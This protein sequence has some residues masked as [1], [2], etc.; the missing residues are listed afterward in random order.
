L[1]TL[2]FRA[3]GQRGHGLCAA[4]AEHAGGPGNARGSQHGGVDAALKGRRGD[5]HDFLHPRNAGRNNV[6]QHGRGIEGLAT[7]DI[8]A[9]A[10]ER[11]DALPQHAAVIAGFFPRLAQ[12]LLVEAADVVVRAF[13]DGHQFLGHR[14]D[15]GVDLV[16]GEFE[17][18]WDQGC[19]VEAL[20]IF[21]NGSVAA[22]ADGVDNLARAL[23]LV[24]NADARIVHV[25][26]GD[27]E[28]ACGLVSGV[29]CDVEA[30]HELALD[31]SNRTNKS[32][33]LT[34]L[35][36]APRADKRSSIRS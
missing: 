27:D 10:F 22:R 1:S 35:I 12:V 18:T 36:S 26:Q 6:H 11:G 2:V 31:R 5:H 9:H 30:L 15:G 34:R 16:G 13:E 8:H 28:V 29:V 25:A 17:L 7:G 32:Y 19:A 14:A 4:H 33:S 21:R 20:G 24:V 3:I 23:N